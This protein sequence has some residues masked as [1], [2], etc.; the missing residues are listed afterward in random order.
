M[1][2][3]KLTES[4][5][6]KLATKFQ[7]GFL[8]QSHRSAKLGDGVCLGGS[9]WQFACA[10]VRIVVDGDREKVSCPALDASCSFDE[11]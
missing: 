7:A 1:N 9:L 8:L 3:T 4:E 5:A 6:R 2:A 10:D 11:A